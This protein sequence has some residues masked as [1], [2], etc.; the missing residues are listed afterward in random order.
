[1][2]VFRPFPADALR[3]ALAGKQR[4][5]VLDRN[6]SFGHH[7]I[8]HQEIKSALYE[9]PPAERPPMRGIIAGLGGRDITPEDIE[10]MLLQNFSPDGAKSACGSEPAGEPEPVTWWKSEPKK[11]VEPE[12]EAEPCT[13]MK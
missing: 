11:E 3:R 9:L 4:V 5:V 12:K 13:A 8:F 6:C 2:R 7:G 1:L 10:Q